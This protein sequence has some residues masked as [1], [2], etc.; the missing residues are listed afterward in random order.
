MITKLTVEN[1]FSI[2]DKREISFVVDDKAPDAEYYS[3]QPVVDGRVSTV[4]LIFGPNASGK[5]NLLKA[6]AFLRYFIVDS[7]N[8]KPDEKILFEDF[9]FPEIP[10]DSHTHLSVDFIIKDFLYSYT[11]ELTK[12]RVYKELLSVKQFKS[13]R[14]SSSVVFS[15]EFNIQK[16]EYLLDIADKKFP[17]PKQTLI[18]NNASIISIGAQHNDEQMLMIQKFW[19]DMKINVIFSGKPDKTIKQRLSY[20]ANYFYT[21][22]DLHEQANTLLSTFDLGLVGT[23]IEQYSV[24]SD[25]SKDAQKQKYLVFGVHQTTKK[26]DHAFPF[27]MESRGTQSLFVL[28]YDLLPNLKQGSVIVLDD[29]DETLHPMM[30]PKIIDIFLSKETNPHRA[31]LIASAHG[32]HVMD[33]LDKYQIFLTGKN[34]DGVSDV[35]R[36]D[37]LK[38]VR[39]DIS[40]V[41]KYLSGAFG[42]VPDV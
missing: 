2:A 39:S 20:A 36:L 23:K 30:L 27:F 42:G 33:R 4:S 14:T 1:F 7:F 15:K 18:R 11:I 37:E 31:Q 16:K 21:H 32:V 24:P 3:K 29:I 34:E 28:L 5:T 9:N 41:K 8:D 13:K 25:E 22:K 40:F 38:D 19:D 17:A 12:E 26:K 6:L 35:W 10:H